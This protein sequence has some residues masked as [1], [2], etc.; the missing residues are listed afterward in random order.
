MIEHYELLYIIPGTKTDEEAKPIVEQIHALLKQHGANVTKT[1]FWGKR[2]LAYE[3]DHLRQGFYDYAEFD[4]ET[5]ALAAL[6]KD[7]RLND[8]VVR[9]QIVRR[10]V[11]SAEQMAKTDALRQRI[12]AKRQAE[13][14]RLQATTIVAG[15]Q[16]VAAKPVAAAPV[17][18]EELEHKLEEILE[19]D[20]VEL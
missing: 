5:T 8:T 17:A 2:K 6:E 20:K 10:Y 18:P 11:Q 3:I 7:L 13:K 15:Q 12:A 1:D 4:L 19:S 9:H 16:P 14:E